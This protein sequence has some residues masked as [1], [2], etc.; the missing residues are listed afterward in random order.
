MAMIECKECKQQVSN[1]AKTCP[2]CGAAVPK[3]VGCLQSIGIVGGVL[4]LFLVLIG[5]NSGTEQNV[6]VTSQ[7]EAPAEEVITATSREIATAYDENEAKG[8]ALYKGKLV[9]VTGK[10]KSVIK[11]ATNDTVIVLVGKQ[12]FQSVHASMLDSEEQQAINVQKDHSVTLRCRGRGEVISSPMLDD[13]V[14][15]N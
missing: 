8:D 3:K 7:A 13:C 14:F 6:A 4:I 15:V 11:D 10:V 5:R 12:M 9:Q 2:S 1:K